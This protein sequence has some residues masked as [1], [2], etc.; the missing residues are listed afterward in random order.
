M[1]YERE[2]TQVLIG[3]HYPH[4]FWMPKPRFLQTARQ[5]FSRR[6]HEQ[7]QQCYDALPRSKKKDLLEVSLQGAALVSCG[8]HPDCRHD[9]A[10]LGPAEGYR[11]SKPPSIAV[12]NYFYNSITSP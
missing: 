6:Q 11:Q 4:L 5:L 9:R 8:S 2:P 12:Y 10:D 3:R 1:I 7:H